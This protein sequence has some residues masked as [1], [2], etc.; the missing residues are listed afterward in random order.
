MRT[1]G[2]DV[3]SVDVVL[4]RLYKRWEISPFRLLLLGLVAILKAAI[5]TRRKSGRRKMTMVVKELDCS[6]INY[7]K[8][9]TR[10]MGMCKG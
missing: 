8:K 9:K 3:V 7:E 5:K 10:R 1:K 4:L 2:E 6:G